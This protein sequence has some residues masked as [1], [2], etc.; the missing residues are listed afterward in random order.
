MRSSH[1]W[2]HFRTQENVSAQTPHF[3][4]EAAQA[5]KGEVKE[6]SN[7]AGNWK[8]WALLPSA[9]VT[10]GP[11]CVTSGPACAASRTTDE[12]SQVKFHPCKHSPSTETCHVWKPPVQVCRAAATRGTLSPLPFPTPPLP[13]AGSDLVT[14]PSGRLSLQGS[15][16]HSVL[17][18]KAGVWTRLGSW[19]GEGAPPCGRGVGLFMSDSLQPHGP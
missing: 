4:E 16:G 3:T 18:G 12:F 6:Q 14:C 10:S 8:S 1:G 9:P 19:G 17:L 7:R 11:A 2:L 15:L 13:P 5:Q